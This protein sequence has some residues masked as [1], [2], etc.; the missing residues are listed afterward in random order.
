MDNARLQTLADKSNED[1]A[2]QLLNF[3]LAGETAAPY[4]A[5]IIDYMQNNQGLRVELVREVAVALFQSPAY[6]LC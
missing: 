2:D 5:D 1:I 3:F 4:R 6:H